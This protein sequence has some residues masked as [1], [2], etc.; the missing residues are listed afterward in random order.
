[1]S[2]IKR[3]GKKQQVRR[4]IN[5]KWRPDSGSRLLSQHLGGIGRGISVSSRP[6]CLTKL[7]PGQPRLHKEKILSRKNEKKEGGNRKGSAYE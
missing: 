6:A 2:R 7:V 3:Y 4:E 5:L 1:L